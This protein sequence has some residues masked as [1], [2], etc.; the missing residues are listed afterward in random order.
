MLVGDVE[1]TAGQ[2]LMGDYSFGV[3]SEDNS[4]RFVGY[5][6]QINPL[7]PDITLQ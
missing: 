6:P 7:W 4:M 5:C 2:V 1:P 3:N